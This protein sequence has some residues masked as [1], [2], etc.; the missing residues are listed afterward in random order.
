[1]HAMFGHYVCM[2]ILLKSHPTIK[3]TYIAKGSKHLIQLHKC[4]EGHNSNLV[5]LS[6][7]EYACN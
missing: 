6:V 4:M 5:L 2:G 7:K 3:Y 1:M